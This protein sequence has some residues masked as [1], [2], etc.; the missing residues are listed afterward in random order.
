MISEH[1][2]ARN[3]ARYGYCFLRGKSMLLDWERYRLRPPIRAYQHH[4]Y[5]DS[6]GSLLARQVVCFIYKHTNAPALLI[7]EA[8]ILLDC[9]GPMKQRNAAPSINKADPPHSERMAESR[10]PSYDGRLSRHPSQV[11][12]STLDHSTRTNSLKDLPVRFSPRVVQHASM[13][14]A[15]QNPARS[16]H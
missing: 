6:F 15:P 1:C 2:T 16:A 4:Y 12:S 7:P 3:V 8:R 13:L 14:L 9:G 5:D 11:R 10:N